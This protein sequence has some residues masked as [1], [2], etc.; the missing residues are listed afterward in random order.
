MPRKS[1][2]TKALRRKAELAEASALM[3]DVSLSDG[4]DQILA[5][6]IFLRENDRA[7]IWLGTLID[8]ER[9]DDWNAVCVSHDFSRLAPLGEAAR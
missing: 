5:L 4:A 6:L 2:P 7:R 1:N 8:E 3:Q 9:T